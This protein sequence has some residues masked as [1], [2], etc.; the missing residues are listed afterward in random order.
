MQNIKINVQIDDQPY[1]E[2]QLAM[3][4]YQR[5]LHVLHELKELGADVLQ[6]DTPLSHTE[7]NFLTAVDAQDILLATKLAIGTDGLRK[8][9]AT[10][11]ARM[12][13]QWLDILEQSDGNQNLKAARTKL[14][15]TGITLPQFQQAFKAVEENA[16]LGLSLNPEH[17][18][19]TGTPQ[20]QNGFETMGMF[21]EPTD[22]VLV[23]DPNLELPDAPM[24]DY[25]I[26]IAGLEKMASTNQPNHVYARH[27]IKPT[28]DGLEL[29]TAAYFPSATPDELVNG[30]KIHLAIEFSNIF[31][32]LA[33]IAD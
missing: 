7:I 12:D 8:L 28:A 20:G 31:K 21:G 16:S 2:E 9:Y 30:H 4:T 24:P 5:N 22:M 18:E 27:Q 32:Y 3:Y 1:S 13:Q 29:F 26:Q 10:K 23:A 19:I 11:M 33:Q 15:V 25:P 17:F 6:A 14:T